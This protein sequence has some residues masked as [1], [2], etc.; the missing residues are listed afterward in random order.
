MVA[1]NKVV[2]FNAEAAGGMEC[3]FSDALMDSLPGLLAK[4]QDPLD[5]F[6]ETDPSADECRVYSD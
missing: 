5:K 1:D 4:T 6:C 3:T 2:M